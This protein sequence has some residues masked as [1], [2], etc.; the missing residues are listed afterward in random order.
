MDIEIGAPEHKHATVVCKIVGERTNG[1]DV[2]WID[3]LN[4]EG[5]EDRELLLTKTPKYVTFKDFADF[6][7]L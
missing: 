4:G 3:V 5:I 1:Y 2:K 6:K 7:E